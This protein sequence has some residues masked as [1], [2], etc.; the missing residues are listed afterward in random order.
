MITKKLLSLK[1][2]PKFPYGWRLETDDEFL[3]RCRKNADREKEGM[4][5][6][7]KLMD[8]IAANEVA[9]YERLKRIEMRRMKKVEENNMLFEQAKRF[10]IQFGKHKGETID[11]VALSDEGLQYLDWLIGQDIP[12][13]LQDALETYLGDPAIQEDLNDFFE[14]KDF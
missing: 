7:R 11:D 6:H 1:L 9:E 3:V 12:E 5:R 8:E 4:A 13:D 2:Y 10:V 14:E